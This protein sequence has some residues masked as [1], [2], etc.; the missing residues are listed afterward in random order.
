MAHQI[1]YKP[2]T[3]HVNSL[4]QTFPGMTSY[5]E[6]YN[7]FALKNTGKHISSRDNQV[8]LQVGIQGW[9]PHYRFHQ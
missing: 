4:F 1:G 5:K 9:H 8:V 6:K 3:Y 2:P 7:Y